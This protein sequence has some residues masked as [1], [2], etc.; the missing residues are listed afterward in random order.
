[1]TL[2]NSEEKSTDS[3]REDSLERSVRLD[4]FREGNWVLAVVMHS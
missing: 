1:M 3:L 4:N 2:G